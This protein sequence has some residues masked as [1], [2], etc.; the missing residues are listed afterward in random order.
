M[1]YIHKFVTKLLP[2]RNET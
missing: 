1:V 2:L